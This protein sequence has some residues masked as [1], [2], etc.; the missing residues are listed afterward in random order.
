MTATT[1][2]Y[3]DPG[4][5]LGERVDD[6]LLRMNVDEKL[7][8]LG[9]A[10]STG[11]LDTAGGFSE[12]RARDKL[13]HGIGHVTRIGGATVLRPPEVA[14]L[15]NAIQ[16]F[17]VS[18]TR[19][20]IPAVIH[21]ESCAGFQARDATCFP[22]A[23][24]LAAT[25]E[26]PLIEAMTRVVRRQM[27]A[28][29]AHH[30]L[31]P[32]LDVARDPRW[33][34]TEETFGE[35]P[36]LIS[37]MG[38]AYVRG[39]QGDDLTEGVVATGKHFLGYGASEGG[40]NW[41][42]AHL[43]QREILEIYA[44]PF[45]AAIKE[46][47]LAS[48][49]N[50]YN[51]IDGV[52]LGASSELLGD[53]LRRRIG[54]DGVV[55]SDYFTVATLHQ[56]HRVANDEA[57]AACA[58]LAAGIDIELPAVHCYGAPLRQALD[59][60]KIDIQLV[61]AAVRRVLLQ[62]L[63]LGLFERPYVD[64]GRAA[65][66]FD[67]VEQRALAHQLAQKSI[68]LL[69]ND[70]S[71][72]PLRKD[73]TALAVIGPSA[74]SVRLLQGDYHYPAHLEIMYGEIREDDMSPRP[75]GAINL[76]QYF[77][78]MVTVIEGIRA[79]VGPQTRLLYAPGCD[80]AG[81]SKAGFA[82]AVDAAQQAEVAV[83]VVGE[84]SG[85][86]EGCTS[87]ESVDRAGLGL[88]GVQQALVEAIAATGK[89]IVVVLINGRPLALPWIA[90]NVAAMVEAWVPGE[91]GGSAIA[92]VLFGDY[93]PAG[94]LPVSL[95]VSVGQVPVF[96]NHKPSGG[97]SQ[98]KGDYADL[99]A[100][101]LFPFGHG[102]SFSRYEYTDLRIAPE[103]ASAADTIDVSLLVHNVGERGGDEVVQLYVHDTIASVTRP[104]KELKGFARLSLAA[105]EAR[106]VCFSLPVALLAFYDRSMDYVVEPGSI[107]I[108]LGAS[109]EDIRLSGRLDIVGKKERLPEWGAFTT[110]VRTESV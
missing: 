73:L 67:T 53:L 34:R 65:E 102:L 94:R 43:G 93:N 38:I 48:M 85:L 26:P 107:E 30:T 46:A 20:G 25:W 42:P 84:K 83:L 29:G 41:A 70:G 75:A 96:Y 45:A 47:K 98:W 28:V 2:T 3:R 101:P 4:R 37:Q 69:K 89:P 32:V 49:M 57:E 60:G 68:V 14:G 50:A 19:L 7:A 52:P 10:W 110:P 63:A 66:V 5:S 55:V 31:A 36:Y 100:R 58:A 92:D 77:V 64:A 80:I 88:S 90:A 78:R 91:E 22:Q 39:V 56:Y 40:M 21:E 9:G 62:K 61:D 13:L 51:E 72:L 6:L 17:L 104:V 87:G 86:V 74:D 108:M 109:S 103:Q 15:A 8:Q 79:K 24:G 105:G 81:E 11:L 33:G 12:A 95:P 106:R 82:A 76:A 97:R 27:R 44:R 71:L 54:F 1:P 23:I 35:D 59:E 99:S 16:R 18:H